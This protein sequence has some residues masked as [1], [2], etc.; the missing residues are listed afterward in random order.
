MAMRSSI[1]ELTPYYFMQLYIKQTAP[2]LNVGDDR[3]GLGDDTKRLIHTS[4][5]FARPSIQRRI[6]LREWIAASNYTTNVLA[7]LTPSAFPVQVTPV[8]DDMPL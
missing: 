6:G 1:V 2:L 3:L 8:S 5:P 7:G 4:L